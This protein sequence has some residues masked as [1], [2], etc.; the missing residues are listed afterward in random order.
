[1]VAFALRSQRLHEAVVGTLADQSGVTRQS[2]REG[3]TSFKF[4]VERVER[5][6]ETPHPYQNNMRTSH[7]VE[8]PGCSNITVT[9]DPQT[10][11]EGGC[12]HLTVSAVVGGDP[13][14]FRKQN[15]G[16]YKNIISL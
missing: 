8:M 4:T 5:I 12:D 14:G 11:T 2:V 1:M 16:R 3:C 15:S 13:N 7:V 9:F 10:E 6:M